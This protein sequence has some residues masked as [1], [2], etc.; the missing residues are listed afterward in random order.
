MDDRDAEVLTIVL[1]EIRAFGA[2]WRLD[3]SD[4]DGRMLRDQLCSL[5]GWAEDRVQHKDN[6]AGPDY[7]EGSV[8][9][10][11]TEELRR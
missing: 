2:A 11:D 9:L 7:T 4:F 6:L 3:W 1:R 8:F 5:A 10:K